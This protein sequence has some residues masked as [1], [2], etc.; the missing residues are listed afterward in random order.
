MEN[1]NTIKYEGLELLGQTVLFTCL[2]ID[3]N[4]VPD[5]LYAYDLRPDDECQGI[6]CEIAP[7]IGVNHW[8]TVL[9]REPI[10]LTDD[11]RRYVTEDDYNYTSTH[12]TLDDILIEASE[13]G[14]TMQ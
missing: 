10:A 8:G 4:T 11:G 7:H 14:V 2:R 9:C 5:G 6:I 3:R 13:E 12:L 1:A